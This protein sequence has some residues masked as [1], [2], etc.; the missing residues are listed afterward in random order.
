MENFLI[1]GYGKLGSHLRHS[2]KSR[3]V[4][5]GISV[6]KDKKASNAEYK[7]AVEKA[8]VIFICVQDSNISAVVKNIAGSKAKLKGKFIYHTSGALTSGE[9]DILTKSGAYCASFHPVQT[10]EKGTSKHAGR[11]EGI[12]IAIEGNKNAVKK[13]AVLARKLRSNP[14]TISRQNKIYHHICCVMASNYLTVLNSK[15]EKTGFSKI[16]ING[17]NKLKFFSIYMPLAKQTLDNIS[18]N[19]A[20]AS[21]TGPVERNDIITI[22]SHLKAIKSTGKDNLHYYILMGIETVKL[23][24]EKKSITKPNA[25]RIYKLFSKYI[26]LQ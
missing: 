8:A 22:E 14:F 10:F 15:I 11:F 21:L 23:A 5:S 7:K 16:K 17:F 1:I 3:Y 20:A 18:L 9:M 12:Y 25:N 4:D 2:L 26:K 13:A 6:I 19:G 24:L